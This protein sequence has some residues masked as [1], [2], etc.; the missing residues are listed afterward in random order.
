MGKMM[1]FRGARL[2]YALAFTGAAAWVLQGYDQGVMNGLLTLPTFTAQFPSI[3]TSTAELESKNSTLQGTVV[4]LY[5]VG[6]AFGALACYFLGD[7]FGRK[8]TTFG[9]AVI[10]LIGVILQTTSFQLAQLIVARIVTGLGV[11]SFTANIPTW[12]GESSEAHQRGSLIMIE[13]SAAIFGVMFVGWL[14]FGFYFIRQ[15]EVAW[16]FPIAFQAIFPIIVMIM[17]PTL[18]ESPRWLVAKDRQQEAAVVLSKLEDAPEDSQAV[19]DRLQLIHASIELDGQ[20]H[21]SNPFARTP[22]RHLNRTL[23][24][25]AVNILAQMSGV[26]VITFYSNTIFQRDLGYSPV[27]SRII[28]SCMQT[29]QFLMATAAVFLIDRFGRRKLLITGALLMCI[30]N[31]GLTGLQSH[32]DNPT[33][34]GC[35]LIF[36]F[37]ALA[38]FP[39]GLFL[40]PFMYSSEIAPLRIRS[41]VTAMSGFSNWMFNF[42]VAEVTPVAFDSI[43][44]KYYLVY[45]CTNLLSVVTFYLFLPET[46]NRTLEDIDAFFVGSRNALQPVKVAKTMPE[47]AAGEWDLSRKLGDEDV[48]V[49][50]S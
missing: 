29:W 8:W 34:A 23:I 9:G 45:V 22:N 15:N 41:K 40:I 5:E 27:L 46:K 26:N 4:A 39:I 38:A 37:L 2:R 48:K 47:G 28:T 1:Q 43:S 24:A 17:V 50:Q 12:V 32:A 31:A 49:E 42:L 25:I 19:R 35:S 33:A 18:E 16:R 10:V 14:E 13:G 3:D 21:S 30:A 36:Y 6:A 20:G 11:G 7:R 44:W